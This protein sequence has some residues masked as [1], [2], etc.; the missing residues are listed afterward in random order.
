MR[1]VR[2]RGEM[3][4]LGELLKLAGVVGTGGEA[5]HL[6]ASTE[7]RVNGELESRRGRQL[8]A[9]ELVRHALATVFREVDVQDPALAGVSVTVTEVRAS[10][11]L[12]HAT[13]FVEPL[14]GGHAD[15]VTA[16]NDAVTTIAVTT[17]STPA[18]ATGT[19]WW[20]CP[21]KLPHPANGPG[22]VSHTNEEPQSS[23][24]CSDE[25]R[26]SRAVAPKASATTNNKQMPKPAIIARQLPSTP[27]E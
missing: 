14:G 15:E 2:I 17:V 24:P 20:G 7:V 18:V 8:R 12:R 19:T 26:E 21:Q 3:I 5:K 11:D 4:R 1:E 9:G 23:I 22:D 27:E 13:V 6:L 16:E 25:L 10:P